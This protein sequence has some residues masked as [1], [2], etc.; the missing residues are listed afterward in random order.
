MTSILFD[1]VGNLDNQRVHA[2]LGRPSNVPFEESV[3]NAKPG[4]LGD[5]SG[6]NM[7]SGAA[8]LC[9]WPHPSEEGH[10]L[11]VPVVVAA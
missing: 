6:A 10:F 4:V 1:R 3:A 11:L 8:G 2:P 7:N 5:E 9:K